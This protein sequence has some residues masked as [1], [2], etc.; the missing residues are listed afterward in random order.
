VPRRPNTA[1]TRRRTAAPC[2]AARRNQPLN[3]Q[4]DPAGSKALEVQIRIHRGR[5]LPL[6][7]TSG[8]GR[9]AWHGSDAII[10][11]RDPLRL[12]H[13]RTNRLHQPM[14]GS[15]AR[16]RRP[17]GMSTSPAGSGT[18]QGSGLLHLVVGADR[19]DP[20]RARV[21]RHLRLPAGVAGAAPPERAGRAQARQ[22][23]MRTHE[24]AGAHDAAVRISPRPTWSCRPAGRRAPSTAWAHRG[25]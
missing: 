6:P 23:L 7:P 22:R 11:P 21:R 18:P 2:P 3:V 4:H 8:S 13:P 20:R 5:P 14:S 24:L 1:V 10:G 15:A 12:H 17:R 19:Q 9:G 16:S 25:R